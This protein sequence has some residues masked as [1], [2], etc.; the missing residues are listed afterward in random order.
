MINRYAGY[1][2]YFQ[3]MFSKAIQL[4]HAVATLSTRFP[5]KSVKK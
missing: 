2:R 4:L 5:H 1:L 3:Q